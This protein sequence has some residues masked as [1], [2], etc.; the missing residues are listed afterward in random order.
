M[1]TALRHAFGWRMQGE[2]PADAVAFSYHRGLQPVLWALLGASV[3][4]TAVLHLL[5]AQLWS[6]EGSLILLAVSLAGLVWLIGL[7]ASLSRLP[8]VVTAA[9]V[10]IRCGLLIDQWL[11][12]DQ[13]A[14]VNVVANPGDLKRP[15]LLKAS[16]LAYPNV[17][18]ELSRPLAVRG[19]GGRFR[20]ISTVALRPDDAAGFAAAVAAVKRRAAVA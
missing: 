17:L 9:G 20:D 4:E 7:I 6:L 3:L 2:I 16:L 14:A 15:E 10:R 19:R 13:I 12:L 8:L 5:L 1:L 18:I 11:P